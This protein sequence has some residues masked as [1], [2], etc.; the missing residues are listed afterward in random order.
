MFV[1]QGTFLFR[2]VVAE[3]QAATFKF[4]GKRFKDLRLYVALYRRAF[5]CS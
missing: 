1:V 2:R 5:T 3:T 4:R